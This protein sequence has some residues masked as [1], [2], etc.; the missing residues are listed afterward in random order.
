MDNAVPAVGVAATLV[1][2][3]LARA[4]GR[5]TGSVLLNPVLLSIALLAAAL[6]LLEIPYERYAAGGRLLAFFLGPAVVALGVPLFRQSGELLRRRRAIGV[7]VLAGSA[8]G[9]L[10]GTVVVILL[11]APGAIARTVA[12]RSVTTPIAI[13]IA[14]RV[15]GIPSL[16]AVLVILSG[17]FGAIVGPPLLRSLGVRSRTAIGFALGAAAHGIGTARAAEEGPREAASAGLAIGLMGVVTALLA[18]LL[19]R[20]LAAVGLLEP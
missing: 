16:T 4:L 7:S 15:G 9:V 17:V 10:S 14:E 12:P 2:F 18:P 5:R 3:A 20:L 19:L 6:L 1:V 13:Q 8:M 11:G